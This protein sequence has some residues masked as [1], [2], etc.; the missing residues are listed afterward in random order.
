MARNIK[1]LSVSRQDLYRISC[2]IN[3]NTAKT[4]GFYDRRFASR[5]EPTKK[6]LLHLKLRKEKHALK[7]VF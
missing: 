6:Q 5:T 1:S 4:A 2:G 7:R 3:R